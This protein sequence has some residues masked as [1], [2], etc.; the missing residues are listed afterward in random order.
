[1]RVVV[2]ENR[3][4]IAT[5]NELLRLARAPLVAWMDSDDVSFP[6]RLSRQAE[7]LDADP[8][9]VC[10]GGAVLEID[11]DGNPISR[12]SYPTDPRYQE[13]GPGL[14]GGT[15]FP[16][17]MMRRDA[18][19]GCGG[20]REPFRM[21]ED[22]DLLL[23]LSER[24]RMANLDE[25]MIGYR[26]HVTSTSRQLSHRWQAYLAAIVAL[27]TERRERG[28]DRL[29]RLEPMSIDLPPEPEQVDPAWNFHWRLARQSLDACNFRTAAIHAGET[30]RL[31][32]LRLRSW[33]L[34]ARVLGT[35]LLRAMNRRA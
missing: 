6:G 8:S 27:A 9:L 30:I 5:R 31:E 1:M 24:G 20:F 25:V 33:K 12:T 28:T 29:Q 22:F 23:R 14:A 17:T 3:G 11:A 32:P 34:G 19:I 35:R 10:I 4:L 7:R 26:Q 16:T 18:A 21:G 2:R 13:L 15:S